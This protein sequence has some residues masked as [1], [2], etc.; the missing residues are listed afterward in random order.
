MHLKQGYGYHAYVSF[1]KALLMCIRFDHTLDR[2]KLRIALPLTEEE[3]QAEADPLLIL[4]N[5]A[6]A[7][8]SEHQRRNSG[9]LNVNW[10]RNTTDEQMISSYHEF[11]LELLKIGNAS[12]A[13]RMYVQEMQ[14]RRMLHFRHGDYLSGGA[15]L[16]WEFTSRYGESP[17]R[18][19]CLAVA[20]VL[21]FAIL[22]GAFGWVAPVSSW[23][24][25]IYFSIVTI[26]TLGYGD[27]HPVNAMGKIVASAEVISGI[28]LFGLFLNLL[29]RKFMR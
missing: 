16:I 19:F 2:A 28:V 27:I 29:T 26:T 17:R 7:A 20:I 5:A 4:E 8:N 12:E 14:R 24:D 13:G 22:Y 25:Y 11:Y 15:Y 1:Q 21:V 10:A 18:W 9:L 3:R 6:H 23:F